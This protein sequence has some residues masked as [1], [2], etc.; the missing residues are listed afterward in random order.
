MIAAPLGMAVGAERFGGREDR[1]VSIV[2][3]HYD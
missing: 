2:Y 1:L 3:R